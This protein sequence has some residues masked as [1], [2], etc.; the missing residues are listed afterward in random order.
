MDKGNKSH[1]SNKSPN[2]HLS[3]FHSLFWTKHSHQPSDAVQVNKWINK[4]IIIS[5]VLPEKEVYYKNHVLKAR[6]DFWL[7]SEN[8]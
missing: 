1:N 4:W 7:Y 2:R 3:L 6:L 8:W 5:M